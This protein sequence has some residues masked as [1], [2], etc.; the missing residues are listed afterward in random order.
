MPPH[1]R[2]VYVTR[3]QISNLWSNL[4]PAHF[5]AHV[6]DNDHF[7]TNVYILP[8]LIAVVVHDGHG[9]IDGFGDVGRRQQLFDDQVHGRQVA[10]NV[11]DLETH[12]PP[13][14]STTLEGE[15]RAY[16]QHGC[17]WKAHV[18]ELLDEFIFVHRPFVVVFAPGG[19]VRV[20]RRHSAVLF[21]SPRVGRCFPVEQRTHAPKSP[22]DRSARNTIVLSHGKTRTTGAGDAAP[23]RVRPPSDNSC[24]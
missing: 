23:Y 8:H 15:K 6:H 16:L 19:A 4:S 22:Q 5:Q 12:T 10:S 7:V 20:G 9:L 11:Y 3:Q 2:A 1:E 17:R 14:T 13:C 24:C 18:G 21:A